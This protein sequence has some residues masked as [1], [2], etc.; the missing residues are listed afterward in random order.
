M[1]IMYVILWWLAVEVIGLVSFPL[2]SRVCSSLP[3]KGYCI[4]KILGLLI[5][6]Y[7]IWMIANLKLLPFGYP[8]L[9]IS[10]VLLT[11]VSLYIGRNN[12]RISSWPRRHIF[13]SELAFGISFI[14]F[15]LIMFGHPDIYY[16]GA[17]DAFFNH[18]F[19]Q[20]I[21]R[22][23]YFPPLDPGFAGETIAYYYGGH[24]LVAALSKISL[25]PLTIAFNLAGAM[26][27]ALA[28]SACYG[29]GYNI[30]GRKIIGIL[31]I[32]FVCI[33][34]YT[35]GALQLWAYLSNK[36]ILGYA[37]TS[38]PNIIE[39]LLGFDFT[40]GNWV[41][42]GALVHYPAFNLLIG[43][44][45]TFGM[46][47]PFQVMVIVLVFAL[48]Q[49]RRGGER[50]WTK[51][52]LLY[53]CLLGLSLGFFAILNTWE[54][55]T[56]VIFTCV[57][58][59]LLGIWSGIVSSPDRTTRSIIN[60]VVNIAITLAII[61]LSL[62]LYIPHYISGVM[63]SFDGLG[64]VETRSNL[65]QF[66]EVATLFVLP[67]FLMLIIRV[68]KDVL[69]GDWVIFL[70]VILCILGSILAAW[71]FEIQLLF[72]AIP[73]GII[74]LIFIVKCKQSSASE[75]VLVLVL[76]GASLVFFGEFLYVNDALSVPW[77]RFNTLMK[78]YLQLWVFLGISAAYAVFYIWNSMRKE[79]KDRSA[80][81]VKV[82]KVIFAVLL[83]ILVLA[84][85]VHP[86][87]TT[88]S[89]LS[90]RNTFWGINRGTLD[91][92]AYLEK[93]H[94]DDYDAIQ[95]IN[96]HIKGHPVILEMPGEVGHYSS[97]IAVLTGLPTVLGWK[98]WQIMW[99][100][101][102]SGVGERLNDITII[103]NTTDN[104]DALE[105]LKKY[106]VE[107]IYIGDLERNGIPTINDDWARGYS[108]EGLEKFKNHPDSY[109]L[110]YEA[111]AVTIYKVKEKQ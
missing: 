57:A 84:S 95:W 105:L 12:L 93:V 107:Y 108:A 72:V 54:Y 18:A 32:I 86:I 98:V 24:V 89:M 30:T 87:A 79:A 21:A 46:S 27:L 16:S 109:E 77:E 92:M 17:C 1:Q 35:S 25:V 37:S 41:L 2:V 52:D 97:R 102:W 44:L 9:I 20:S 49:K 88:T 71:L 42:P 63:H 90:G 28:V 22:G 6:T 64:F 100:H 10:I 83:V 53:I 23:G 59:V 70:V 55:P 29:L 60:F 13:F 7:L 34:G 110:V 3:D 58:I 74:S 31:T 69:K 67:I 104:S 19:I 43:D 76:I 39:W 96:A 66:L 56:Y 81:M 75:F 14:V 38:A 111:N 68:T 15:V 11:S 48:F 62:L 99:R 5:W 51:D 26:F 4:S 106:D 36:E 65:T 91:G 8:N 94:E 101:D 45:H 47:I 82:M 85:A 50:I 61:G 73:M 80:V 103:Y 33:L 78:V 40:A